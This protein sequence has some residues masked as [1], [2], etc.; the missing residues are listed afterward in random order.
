MSHTAVTRLDHYRLLG[1]SGVRVSPLCLGTMTFGIDW[2]WG[3]DPQTSEAVFERYVEAGG[4]FIDTANFYTNGTSET[5]L[6]Q[7][8]G[9]RR[10][11]FVLATKYTLN[12]ERGDPNAGGNH[13]KNMVRSVEASLRRLGTDHIDL[14]WLHAWDFTTPVDEVM[15]GL[16]DLVRAGKVLYLGISDAPA[17]KVA[18]ANTMAELRG[19]SRFV[20]LQVEYSLVTRDIERDLAPMACELGLAILPWS[21]LAG[22]VLTGKYTRADL[23]EQDRQRQSASDAPAD[24]FNTPDRPI[25][26][27]EHK[28]AVAE[29]VQ[30]VAAA[31]GRTP[32]QVAINW[33]LTRPGVVSP[34]IGARRLEQLEDNLAA[35][36]FTLD[37]E[38]LEELD[39][40]SA[41]RLGFPH[42]FLAGPFVQ[43]IIRGGT[44]IEPRVGRGQR[45]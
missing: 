28:I 22:G 23:E 4:N 40:S 8:M 15:R 24:P 43:D 34:I 32:A 29:A 33:L 38:H 37:P 9:K 36:D 19:W 44:V 27:T 35:L 16:D 31:I 10:D 12:M 26:L 20:A 1:R 42:D 41:I 17:W 13:R 18:Q 2:G 3:S 25:A 30:R 21:P 39:A 7:L 45:D 6:G 14:Y 11:R 5:M